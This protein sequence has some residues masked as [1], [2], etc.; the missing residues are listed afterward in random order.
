MTD[1]EL[2]QCKRFKEIR[3]RLSL[4]QSDFAKALAISQG[5]ASDIEN[6]RKNISDRLIEILSLKYNVSENW[7]K[8][9][10]GEMFIQLSRDEQI[11]GFVGRALHDES[12]TFKKRLIS[13]LSRLD[14]DEWEALE[15]VAIKLKDG[16]G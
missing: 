13:I 8:L 4:K 12:D 16:L 2:N 6:G 3:K 14:E 5:H 10:Q 7:L 9:G 1:V 11:A 15:K